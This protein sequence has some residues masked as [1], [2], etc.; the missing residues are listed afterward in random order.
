MAFQPPM[1]GV[2]KKE[3][4]EY[5]FVLT[6]VELVIVVKPCQLSEFSENSAPCKN[7]NLSENSE[8]SES[9]SEPKKKCVSRF[10]LLEM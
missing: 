3:S 7:G 5:G 10:C 9:C 1:Q 8:P 6:C 2:Y 4:L